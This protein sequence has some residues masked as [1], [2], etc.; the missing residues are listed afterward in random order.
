[1]HML[2]R[3]GLNSAELDTVRVS[4][5]HS[6]VLAANGE[7]QTNEESTVYV[8]DLDL[9]VKVQIIEDTPQSCRLENSAKITD[10]PLSGP[11]VRNHTLF[12]TAGKSQCNTR[13]P[14]S[15]GP[16]AEHAMAESYFVQKILVT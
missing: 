11:V 9:F 14:R 12:K 7:V 15:Q 1:M 8:Y 4:R 13:E 3:T 2:S 10:I 6:T 16:R 5:K